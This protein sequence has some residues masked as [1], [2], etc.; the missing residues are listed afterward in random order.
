MSAND[1]GHV[2]SAL[3]GVLEKLSAAAQ[4]SGR[5]TQVMVLHAVSADNAWLRAHVQPAAAMPCMKRKPSM[6]PIQPRLVAVS[7]TKPVE[8]IKEAYDAG[9]RDFGENYVQVRCIDACQACG[10]CMHDCHACIDVPS[11]FQELLDKAPQLPHDIRWHYV[12]HLQSNKAKA[13]LGV[14][15]IGHAHKQLLQRTASYG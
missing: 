11:L 7:K 13:L 9:H 4:R 2:A 12:G 14:A 3:K 15:S 1:Q 8:L 6:C 10:V 5:G